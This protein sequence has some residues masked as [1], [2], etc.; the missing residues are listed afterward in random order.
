[1]RT[2]VPALRTRTVFDRTAAFNAQ[3]RRYS[4]LAGDEARLKPP[5]RLTA[6]T[7]LVPV[8]ADNAC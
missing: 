5:Q 7:V 8:G 3:S 1:M 2:S 6:S 4:F